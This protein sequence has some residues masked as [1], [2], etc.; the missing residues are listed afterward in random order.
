MLSMAFVSQ[1]ENPNG[2]H[3]VHC[4]NLGLLKHFG[5]RRKRSHYNRVTNNYKPF[6]MRRQNKWLHQGWK[7]IHSYCC[8]SVWQSF[9]TLTTT[10]NDDASKHEL[11]KQ[12]EMCAIFILGKSIIIT[13]DD[14]KLMPIEI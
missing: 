8:C 3:F 6:V 2:I 10:S 7:T 4:Q 11:G 9:V 5:T 12:K 14:N 13:V 1:G